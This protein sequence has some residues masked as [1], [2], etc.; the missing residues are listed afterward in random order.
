MQQLC[1]SRQT[2]SPTGARIALICAII[3][4]R[5]LVNICVKLCVVVPVRELA[6]G[7]VI[8]RVGYYA[9]LAVPLAS[10]QHTNNTKQYLQDE[11]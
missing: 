1:P 8:I 4:V 2:Q 7:L 9:L 11:K 6:K 5:Q 10:I 3:T